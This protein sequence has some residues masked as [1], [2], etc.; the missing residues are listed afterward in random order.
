[1][2]FTE[3]PSS[4]ESK[5]SVLEMDRE[6]KAALEKDKRVFTKKS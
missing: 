5:N 2:K 4:T 6:G 3:I 1:M